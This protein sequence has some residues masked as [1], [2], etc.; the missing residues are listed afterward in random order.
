MDMDA[1][2]L[3]QC[4][5]IFLDFCIQYCMQDQSFRKSIPMFIRS[6]CVGGGGYPSGLPLGL[7]PIGPRRSMYA[8]QKN[9]KENQINTL[10]IKCP[11][12]SASV[13]V[14]RIHKAG[15]AYGLSRLTTD[16]Q[17][18]TVLLYINPWVIYMYTILILGTFL[19]TGFYLLMCNEL[20]KIDI[21]H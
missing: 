5:G 3:G 9:A 21:Y 20:N 13:R 19:T 1:N 18:H 14:R 11:R 4:C 7:A 2:C 17:D 10:K 16:D 15:R 6:W 8:T 12:P